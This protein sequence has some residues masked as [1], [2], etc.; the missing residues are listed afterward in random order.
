MQGGSSARNCHGKRAANVRCKRGFKSS[1]LG[2]LGKVVRFKHPDNSLNVFAGYVLSAIWYSVFSQIGLE[3]IFDNL[4]PDN[5]FPP[6]IRM[7]LIRTILVAVFYQ[8]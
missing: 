1:Y 7:D 6:V 3:I 5:S 4:K 8:K 2:P